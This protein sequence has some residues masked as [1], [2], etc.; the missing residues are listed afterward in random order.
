[1]IS[2]DQLR[3]RGHCPKSGY[4]SAPAMAEPETLH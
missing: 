3:A 2:I 1:M 4:D